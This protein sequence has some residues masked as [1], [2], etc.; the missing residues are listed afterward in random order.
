M[1]AQHTQ[2]VL[3]TLSDYQ[4]KDKAV[5]TLYNSRAKNK[6][7]PRPGVRPKGKPDITKPYVSNVAEHKEQIVNDDAILVTGCDGETVR[8]CLL[9]C[10]ISVD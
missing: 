10:T 3:C 7:M 6:V 4:M 8:V 1:F 5:A 2:P 9:A